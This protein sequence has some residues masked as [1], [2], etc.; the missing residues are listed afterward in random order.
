MVACIFPSQ[1]LL[2]FGGGDLVPAGTEKNLVCRTFL[3]VSLDPTLKAMSPCF[4]TLRGYLSLGLQFHV[5]KTKTM[6]EPVLGLCFC[7]YNEKL[8]EVSF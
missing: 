8:T 5:Y 6:N 2:S 3:P 1:Y 7:D 4:V